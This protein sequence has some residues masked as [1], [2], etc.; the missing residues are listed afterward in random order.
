MDAYFRQI[1]AG[2]Y[3]LAVLMLQAKAGMVDVN[4]HPRKL[5]VKFADSNK[6]YQI[7]HESLKKVFGIEKIIHV[8]DHTN[9]FS[10][11]NFSS[12]TQQNPSSLFTGQDQEVTI[13]QTNIFDQIQEQEFSQQENLLL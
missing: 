5:E 13:Q 10:R 4:V 7:I 8:A 12:N 9:H 11:E 2:E 6:I 3:P 1:P